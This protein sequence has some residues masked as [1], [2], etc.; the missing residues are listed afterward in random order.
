MTRAQRTADAVNGI[1]LDRITPGYDSDDEGATRDPVGRFKLL[2]PVAAS[3][4]AFGVRFVEGVGRT[5][6][7]TAARRLVLE[8]PSYRLIDTQEK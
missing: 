7:E 6:D 2:T 4:T 1:E 5:D 8:F 3:F